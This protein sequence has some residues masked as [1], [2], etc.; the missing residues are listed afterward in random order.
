[1]RLDDS[2]AL[3]LTFEKDALLAEYQAKTTRW[4]A[5]QAAALAVGGVALLEYVRGNLAAWQAAFALA[6]A[7]GFVVM[8]GMV[9]GQYDRKLKVRMQRLFDR[10]R[11]LQGRGS[12]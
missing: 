2:E 9:L 3:R 12:A 7:L 1:M 11:K 5:L 8:A 10:L 6:A 4:N